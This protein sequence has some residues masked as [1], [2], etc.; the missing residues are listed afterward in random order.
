MQSAGNVLRGRAEADYDTLSAVQSKTIQQ[1]D[2]YSDGWESPKAAKDAR[3]KEKAR[4]I[5]AERNA[6]PEEHAE[7]S[8]EKSLSRIV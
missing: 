2:A 3:R 5:A 1:A 4:E 7:R 6:G 8:L